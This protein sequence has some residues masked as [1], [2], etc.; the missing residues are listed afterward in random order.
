MRQ[1]R[2]LPVVSGDEGERRVLAS[3]GIS[4]ARPVPPRQQD[5]SLPLLFKLG[6]LLAVLVISFLALVG[7]ATVAVGA[8][9]WL[10]GLV[11]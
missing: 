9:L 3:R 2:E 1:R 10:R 7:A 11:W 4:P 5:P 8:A 6:M